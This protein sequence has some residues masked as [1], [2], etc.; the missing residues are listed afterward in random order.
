MQTV[1]INPLPAPLQ[2]TFYVPQLTSDPA[3]PAAQ[4][5]WVLR[6]GS[7]ST[8]GGKVRAFLGLGAPYLTVGSAGSF[9]YKLSYQTK[10]G[11]IK[12]ATLS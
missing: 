6:Q 4:D 12:R 3:S 2:M 5:M 8:G 10:E 9:T 7:G 1:T 11:T